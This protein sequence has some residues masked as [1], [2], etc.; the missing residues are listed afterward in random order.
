M[1]RCHTTQLLLATVSAL[2]MTS[3]WAAITPAQVNPIP[4][5]AEQAFDAVAT[6]CLPDTPG[7]TGKCYNVGE[8]VIVDV[9]TAEEAQLQGAPAKVV[10]ITLKD[11]TVFTPDMGKTIVAK[12]STQMEYTLNGKKKQTGLDKIASV[13]TEQISVNVECAYWKSDTLEMVSEPVAFSNGMKALADQG[14]KVPITM[15]NSGGRS[16]LCPYSFLDAEVV[17]AGTFDAF[18]EIDRAGDQ[19]TVTQAVSDASGGT[20]PAGAHVAGLGGFNGNDY[21]NI[22]NGNLGYPGRPTSK[23]P[24]LGFSPADL[25]AGGPNGPS[26]GW[27]DSGL[28][29]FIADTACLP[30]EPEAA[31]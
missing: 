5:T 19:Y 12:D 28:P 29:I 31:P 11:G 13:V 8:V 27:K 23:M 30:S 6:G 9:R 15:C 18:Y 4:I 16:T 2:G 21:N 14:V 3:A 7:V 20:L 26:T 22:F 25:A 10:S 1:K 17:P 24:V